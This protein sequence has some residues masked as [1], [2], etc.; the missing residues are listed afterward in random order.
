VQDRPTKREALRFLE[1]V[2][3]DVQRGEWRD[4]VHAKVRL[5]DWMWATTVNLRPSSRAR[6]ESYLR[7]HVLFA[8]ARR[9]ARVIDIA[10]DVRG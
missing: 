7:N 10:V 2:G 5:D 8:S 1:R 4:P 6:D 9:Q 3:T